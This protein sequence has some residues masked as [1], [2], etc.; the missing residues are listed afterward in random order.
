MSSSSDFSEA[1]RFSGQK[2]AKEQEK[3]AFSQTCSL[4]SQYL[5]ENGTFGDLSLGMMRNLEANGTILFFHGASKSYVYFD[6]YDIAYLAR[7]ASKIFRFVSTFC[8]RVI[9]FYNV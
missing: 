6:V 2:S 3:S 8:C 5:K 9:F 7:K 1:G 4:L